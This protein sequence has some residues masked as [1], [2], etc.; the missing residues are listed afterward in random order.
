VV[1]RRLAAVALVVA[2]AFAACRR[3]D[4]ARRAALEASWQ[5]VVQ[6]AR[7]EVEPG[8]GALYLRATEAIA[9]RREAV[10]L[11]IA[12]GQDAGA[13]PEVPPAAH[14][15]V[16]LLVA[17]HRA[18]G[19]I[20]GSRC[21]GRD[22]V[23]SGGL[24]A[25]TLA[26][27]ALA[28]ASPDQA[29][30]RLAAVLYLGHR[31]RDEGPNLLTVMIGTEIVERAIAWASARGQPAPPSLRAAAPPSTVLVRTLAAEAVCVGIL[32]ASLPQRQRETLRG[33]FADAVA[34]LAGAATPADG[35]AR[36]EELAARARRDRRHPELVA[37]LPA[38]ERQL[39]SLHERSERH[40]AFFAGAGDE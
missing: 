11:A 38:L 20:V 18:G 28:T 4:A 13:G 40:R 24:A 34:V 37:V 22:A 17:W 21:D 39:A 3:D 2:I 36:I 33:F 12:A 23:D 25:L 15:A 6:L 19:G 30:E 9:P 26:E 5:E 27:L 31:L 29:A 7:P 35:L 1:T 16:A 8:D 10:R 32:T 14:E